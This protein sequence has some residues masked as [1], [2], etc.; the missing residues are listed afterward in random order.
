[1]TVANPFS[2][3]KEC[4]PDRRAPGHIP[5]GNISD[6]NINNDKWLPEG[7]LYSPEDFSRA[8]CQARAGYAPVDVAQ[9]EQEPHTI[10]DVSFDKHIT[11]TERMDL[12]SSGTLTHM[13]L[14]DMMQELKNLKNFFEDT[15]QEASRIIPSL[16]ISNS[17]CTFPL[18]LDSCQSFTLKSVANLANRR[19]RNPPPPLLVEKNQTPSS[20]LPYPGIPT[21]FFD[22]P[23]SYSDF[24]DVDISNTSGLRIEDMINNLRLQCS[25]MV[26][27]TPPVDNPWNSRSCSA[28]YEPVKKSMEAEVVEFTESELVKKSIEAKVVEF[29]EPSIESTSFPSNNVSSEFTGNR[30]VTLTMPPEPQKGTSRSRVK[31]GDPDKID[32]ATK[33]LQTAKYAQT[34][35]PNK[36]Q[37]VL[38]KYTSPPLLLRSSLVKHPTFRPRSP[39]SVRFALSP[40]E[41]EKDVV[42]LMYDDVWRSSQVSVPDHYGKAPVK[43]ITSSPHLNPASDEE[44]LEE[45]ESTHLI[46]QNT[47]SWHPTSATFKVSS[48]IKTKEGVKPII[49]KSPVRHSMVQNIFYGNTDKVNDRPQRLLEFRGRQSLNR[50][51]KGPIFSGKEHKRAT[52]SKVFSV[53]GAVTPDGVALESIQRKSRMPVP[54]RNIL[55]RFK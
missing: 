51:I 27:N 47:K 33:N 10:V 12:G 38:S 8:L 25:S 48:T 42:S 39:K 53:R 5:W 45:E 14:V 13:E 30:L 55:T 3:L 7:S 54:L 28:A 20:E 6:Q 1:M 11:T 43:N 37:E 4:L 26:I 2:R 35:T 49:I 9:T 44:G 32:T 23:S 15:S 17:H 40:L 46:R 19:G 41:F 21:P 24:P 50:I 22:P 16:M 36:K 29:A 34:D 31:F 18:S 52:V